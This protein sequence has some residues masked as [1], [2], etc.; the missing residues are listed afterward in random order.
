MLTSLIS[1][2]IWAGDSLKMSGSWHGIVNSRQAGFSGHNRTGSR[3][4]TLTFYRIFLSTLFDFDVLFDAIG[5]LLHTL[6]YML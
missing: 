5:G 1:T 6:L 2:R 3:R 4:G